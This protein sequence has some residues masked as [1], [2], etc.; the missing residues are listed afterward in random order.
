[1][2][3]ARLALSPLVRGQVSMRS[4]QYKTGR[5]TCSSTARQE[6]EEKEEEHCCMQEGSCPRIISLAKALVSL[7]LPVT[8]SPPPVP[9]PM[10]SHSQALAQE[11]SC[12]PPSPPPHPP[13]LEAKGP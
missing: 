3:L 12:L 11:L 6:E 2:P 8:L 1:M 13:C 4:L 7:P 5:A 9:L 10:P